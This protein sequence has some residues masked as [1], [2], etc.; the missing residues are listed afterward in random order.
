MNLSFTTLYIDSEDLNKIEDT[1]VIERTMINH[2]VK[3]QHIDI[4]SY[5]RLGTRIQELFNICIFVHNI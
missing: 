4:Y 2:R 3:N 5:T 1:Q